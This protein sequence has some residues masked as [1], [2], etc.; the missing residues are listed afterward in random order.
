MKKSMKT[1]ALSAAILTMGATANAAVIDLN[2]YGASAQYLFWNTTAP[3]FLTSVR[4][5]ASTSKTETTDKKHGITQGIGCDGGV[6]TINIRYS[7]KASYDGIRAVSNTDPANT[8][9]GQPGWRPMITGAGNTALLCQ[10]VHVGA[11]D[12]AGSTFTQNST[13]ALN[14]PLG[15]AATTRTFSGIPTAGLTTYQPVVVP[16]GFF[17]NNAIKVHTCAGGANAGNLCTTATAAAD[18]G[19]GTCAQNT[20]DN[21]TREQ[22]VQIFSGQAFAW[23]DFGDSYSVAGDPTNSIVACLRHAGSG[24]HATFDKVIFTGATPQFLVTAENT[25]GPFIYFNDGSTEE[26]KCVNGNTTTA[27]TGSAVGAIGYADADQSVGA[28]G[29]SQNV[30]GIKYNGL[31]GRR[32][33]VRNGLYDFFSNQWLYENPT[34]T[35]AAQHT[36]LTQLNT[37]ASNPANIPASKAAFW[38]AAGEMVFNKSSDTTYP[39]YVGAA[40][41]QTP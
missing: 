25:A 39:G 10:D 37:F 16:F 8:C 23:T 31:L 1:L 33:V 6:N 26:M 9:A 12:V 22:A 34:K 40:L 19:T 32:N 24:T 11:S 7:S 41:K 36:L 20:I 13:G 29:V 5:C 18:C 4:G 28:A 35:T 27:T 30:V 15:G 14:G 38:A 21:V 2:V 17:A 3:A